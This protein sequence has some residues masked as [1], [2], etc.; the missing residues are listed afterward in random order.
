MKICALTL[1]LFL[2]IICFHYFSFFFKNF[3]FI[4]S[5][6]ISWKTHDIKTWPLTDLSG[7]FIIGFN[8]STSIAKICKYTFSLSSAQCQTISNIYS[9]IG[10]LM[11][12][13]SEFFV[14]GIATSSS[15][16]LQMNKITFSLTKADWVNQIACLSVSWYASNSESM[17]SSDGSTV[18]SF[19]TFASSSSIWHLYFAGL[20]MNDGSVVT[21]RYKSN[22][23][24]LYVPGTALNGDYLVATCYSTSSYV[25]MYSLSSSTFTIKSFSGD[26]L[27]EWGVE[28][29]S[30]R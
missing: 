15:N 23:V 13:N 21:A 8:S 24:V 4:Y 18:Y 25:V 20:A 9:G 3:N 10:H 7:Y 22:I 29:S 19:F 2:P 11:I 27:Q 6:G 30:G 16:N 17:L 1:F 26:V 14:L 12:S 5:T 28:P